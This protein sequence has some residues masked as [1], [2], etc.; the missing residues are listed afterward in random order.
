MILTDQYDLEKAVEVL[1]F[2]SSSPRTRRRS[3]S[4]VK[5]EALDILF[6]PKSASHHSCGSNGD[7][8]RRN[9]NFNSTKGTETEFTIAEFIRPQT[10]RN[11]FLTLN[12][13][14]ETYRDIV[15]APMAKTIEDDVTDLGQCRQSS[16][17]ELNNSQLSFR[18][19]RKLK[20]KFSNWNELWE[21]V[22]CCY[23]FLF[24]PTLAAP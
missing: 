10:R 4:A 9:Q 6:E 15:L 23:W 22:G 8:S 18:N 21:A 19:C 1:H 7:D 20:S 2:N 12:S 16:P 17:R 13:A 5:S 3:P 11:I 24:F 14:C